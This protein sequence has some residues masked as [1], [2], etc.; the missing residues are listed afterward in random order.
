LVS[1][2]VLT[3]SLAMVSLEVAKAFICRIL[4]VQV[5]RPIVNTVM[6]LWV[7]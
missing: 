2:A 4:Q 7:L 5:G 1:D 3:I 6:N